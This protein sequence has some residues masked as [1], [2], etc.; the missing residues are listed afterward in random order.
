MAEQRRLSAV[1]RKSPGRKAEA[2]TTGV[3]PEAVPAL[4]GQ[5]KPFKPQ[6]P[7]G[8]S[9]AEYQAL[10]PEIIARIVAEDIERL[11]NIK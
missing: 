5:D 2:E 4:S 9:G 7:E 10:E 8:T 11:C 6:Q 1:R 3:R